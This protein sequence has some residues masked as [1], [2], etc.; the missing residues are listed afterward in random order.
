MLRQNARIG[1]VTRGQRLHSKILLILL[2][3]LPVASA[4][5]AADI[6]QPLLPNSTID[7][8]VQLS[9]DQLT[10]A[11]EKTLPTQAG[12]WRSWK[13]WHG[14]KSKYRAWRGPL[15]ISISGDVISVQAHI[16][17]WIKAHKK[18]LGAVKLKGG[19]GIDEPPRQALI[20][21]QIR[22]E[23]RPDW[24]LNPKFHILPT[25]FLDRCEMTIANIDVTPIIEKE[26]R[27]QMQKSLR[28]ALRKLNPD[29]KAIH[30]QAQR[31]WSLLQE[32][33]E[34]GQGNWLMLRPRG[35][36]LSRLDGQGKYINAHL[37][38]KLQPGLVT[39]PEPTGEPAPLPPIDH[40]YPRSTGLNLQLGMNLDFSSLNQRLSDMLAGKRFVIRGRKAGIKKLYLAG[41]GQEIWVRMELTG[42][43]NGMLA[44][45]VRVA[46]DA[47]EQK[48]VLHDLV[49][50]YDTE[51][52]SVGLIAKAFHESIRQTLESMANQALAQHLDLLN[53][54]LG[55]VLKKITPAGVSL[56]MSALQLRTAQIHIVQQGIRLEGAATGSARLVL[57]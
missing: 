32:P 21:M 37:A 10:D 11:A 46:Y 5:L 22:L 28:T 35:V 18:I 9:L 24:T 8:P 44:L 38:I 43:I 52:F 16:R 15:N 13:D 14:I 27:K 40:Y 36:A 30:R 45:R 54:R 2:L 39:G 57:H 12:N 47:H 26:F 25:R 4:Q 19:C 42:D 51:D 20:G 6:Q 41:S 33:I 23:W 50:D 3:W 7:I 34:L 48:L 29:V 49:F 1:S 17:Y 31:T 56:D 55:T 53:E